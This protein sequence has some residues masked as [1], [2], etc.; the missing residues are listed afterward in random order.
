M[1]RLCDRKGWTLAQFFALSDTE[2]DFWR[3]YE[4]RRENAY[5]DLLSS[6]KD[7]QSFDKLSSTLLIML[8]RL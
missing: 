6:I 4:I 5:A 7:V 1:A 2:Q 3:A 8:D